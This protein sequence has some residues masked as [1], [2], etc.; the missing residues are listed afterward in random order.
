MTAQPQEKN[1]MTPGEYLAMERS[2]LDIKHELFNGEIFTMVGAGRNHNR[3]NIN[4][5][6]KLY[7]KFETDK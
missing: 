7:N 2:A 5:I 4:L 1:Q 6:A 3:I